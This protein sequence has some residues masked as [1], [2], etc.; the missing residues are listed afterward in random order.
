MNLGGGLGSAHNND[1][2]LE[3]RKRVALRFTN[4]LRYQTAH[5]QILALPLNSCE[6]LGQWL[7]LSEPQIPPLTIEMI[8][9]IGPLI[10]LL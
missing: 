6:T 7:T 10:E 2:F 1:Y 4:G 9:R 8:V 5:I 3:E